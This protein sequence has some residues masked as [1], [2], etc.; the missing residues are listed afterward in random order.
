MFQLTVILEMTFYIVMFSVMFKRNV[1][2]VI[3]IY[4]YT[5]TYTYVHTYMTLFT[6]YVHIYILR[7]E[8]KMCKQTKFNLAILPRLCLHMYS[9]IIY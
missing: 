4:T 6:T 1:I 7:Y 2:Y 5:H 9:K 3:Y 8:R